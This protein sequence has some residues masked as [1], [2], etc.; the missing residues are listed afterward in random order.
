M[1]GLVIGVLF[2]LLSAKADYVGFE[3]VCQLDDQSNVAVPAEIR[4]VLIGALE[5]DFVLE[6]RHTLVCG[7]CF[8]NGYVRLL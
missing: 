6:L 1:R 7:Q 3:L 5:E 2:Q 4:T 8:A